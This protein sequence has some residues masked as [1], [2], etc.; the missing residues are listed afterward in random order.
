MADPRVTKTAMMADIHL[1]LKPRSDIALLNAM[2]H[3]VIAGPDRSQF[4]EQHTSGF[5][6]LKLHVAKYTPEHASGLTGSL[7]KPFARWRGCMDAQSGFIGWTM[8]INHSTQ[9][10][11][12]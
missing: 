8:G 4:I 9:G 1:P 10:L 7:P 12:P 6:A 2:I 11:R 3:V 5:D